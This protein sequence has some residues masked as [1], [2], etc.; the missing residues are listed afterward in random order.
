M[1]PAAYPLFTP[2]CAV[3][4]QGGHVGAGAALPRV[5]PLQRAHQQPGPPRGGARLC[6]HQRRSSP[7]PPPPS[8]NYIGSLAICHTPLLQWPL[9]ISSCPRLCGS[10]G[11]ACAGVTQTVIVPQRGIWGTA[12]IGGMNI[13]RAID[14]EGAYMRV[15]SAS[16]RVDEVVA[17][18]PVALMKAR[19][20]SP[21][22]LP[23][24]RARC[25]LKVAL[26]RRWMWRASSLPCSRRR[27]SCWP[28][29]L[30]TTSSW[31][32][33]QVRADPPHIL[34]RLRR[35]HRMLAGVADGWRL[36]RRGPPRAQLDHDARLSA[37]AEGHLLRGVQHPQLRDAW[38]GA[39]ALC[40]LPARP[41]LVA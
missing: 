10:T 20:H 12:G 33:P 11:L 17:G 21:P 9:L 15:E 29:A 31:S 41:A 14:N 25:E 2:G 23:P 39:A 24:L 37:H 13:D 3:G 4:P 7:P 28:A 26:G 27:N 16:E 34:L 18:H 35:R 6:G 22:P 30:W 19:S 32:I 38:A 40:A 36:R 8:Q 1:Y 5:P